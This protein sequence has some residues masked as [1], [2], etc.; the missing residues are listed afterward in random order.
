MST[1]GATQ[2]PEYGRDEIVCTASTSGVIITSG[3]GFSNHF[4]MPD[5]QQSAVRTYLA[6]S[7][8]Q[9][10]TPGYNPQGRG[11]PDLSFIGTMFP[12]IVGGSTFTFSGTSASTPVAAALCK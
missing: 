1:V 11:Y 8:G 6:S 5:Y 12:V 3:G 10:A 2:G 4:P 9:K 7:A